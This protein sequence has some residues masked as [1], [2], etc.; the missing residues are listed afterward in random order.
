MNGN[1]KGVEGGKREGGEW[2]GSWNGA[3]NLL[4]PALIVTKVIF[5]ISCDA[6]AMDITTE[7]NTTHVIR[8]TCNLNISA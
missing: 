8:L 7:Y 1:G 5:Y 6:I 3:A 2:D 4:R